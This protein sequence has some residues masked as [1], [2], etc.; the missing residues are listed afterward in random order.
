[1]YCLIIALLLNQSGFSAPELDEP[2]LIVEVIG[3]ESD[4][5]QVM[6]SFISESEWVF[7]PSPDRASI[8]CEGEINNGA[9][10]VELFDV[11]PG[12]YVAIAFHDIDSDGEFDMEE[13]MI[14][15]SGATPQMHSMGGPPSFEDMCFEYSGSVS[16][17]RLTVR[18]MEERPSGP[19]PGG[20][21]PRGGGPGG[22]GIR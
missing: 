8:R 19:P 20:G 18:E 15:I 1:M 3:F 2:A 10:H 4:E 6:I 7:P 21:S 14:G 5:G 11:P 9:A 13:E 22:G 12:K 17:V 16:V